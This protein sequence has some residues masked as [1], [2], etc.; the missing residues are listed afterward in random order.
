VDLLRG[1]LYVTPR[2]NLTLTGGGRMTTFGAGRID[3]LDRQRSFTGA[4]GNV[5]M[6]W[7]WTPRWRVDAHY[8]MSTNESDLA[9][10]QVSGSIGPAEG[11]QSGLTVRRRFIYQDFDGR[12]TYAAA[13]G[14]TVVSGFVRGL[15]LDPVALGLPTLDRLTV[16]GG[17]VDVHRTVSGFDL[18][19]GGEAAAG[20]SSSSRGDSAVFHEES[21]RVQ[22]SRRTSRV[23]V[24]ANAGIRNTGGSYFYPVTGQSWYGGVDL[25]SEANRRFQLRGSASRAYLL[26]DVVIQRGD[27]RTDAFSAGLRGPRFDVAAEYADT[28]STA[29]GVLETAL[30]TETNPELLLARRPE[31]FGFLS[32]SRQLRRSVDGRLTLL[33]GLDVF[34]RGRLDRL[35]LPERGSTGFLNQNLAQVG[36]ILGVRQLQLEIGWEYLEYWSQAVSTVDRRFHVR[37]RRDLLVR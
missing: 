1:N 20:P 30:I 18:T 3:D 17:Q 31:L 4:G 27:D 11:D 2:Q 35:E 33:P 8:A 15:S 34:A 13:G 7:Q 25:A 36:A 23:S 14:S 37:V 9:L 16:A 21:G 24:S 10:S 32:A 28:R 12:M 19:L 5:G 29:K 6:Q 22:A 26:R